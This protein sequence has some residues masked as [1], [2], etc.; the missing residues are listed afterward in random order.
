[1]GCALRVVAVLI[2]ALAFAPG[3]AAAAAKVKPKPAPVRGVLLAPGQFKVVGIVK[4]GRIGGTWHAGTL[5]KSGRFV[6]FTSQARSARTSARKLKGTARRK[7][8][9]TAKRYEGNV[10]SH[11]YYCKLKVPASTGGPNGLPYGQPPQYPQG[12]GAAL[13]FDI[14]DAVGLAT[15][16][17]TPN[18]SGAPASNIAAIDGAGRLQDAVVSGTAPVSQFLIAPN[19]KLYVLFSYPTALDGTYQS[20]CL[21]AEVE[22]STGVPRCIDATLSSVIWNSSYGNANPAIQFDDAGAIYYLGTAQ[23]GRLVLRRSSNAIVTDLIT[24]NAYA[25]DFVVLG[26]GTVVLTG[27]TTAT[28]APWTRRLSPRGELRTLRA[29]TSSFLRRFPDGNVYFGH[30]ESGG[31]GVKRYLAGPDAVDARNWIGYGRGSFDEPEENPPH[32]D[33]DDLCGSSSSG[34]QGFCSGSGATL[35]K[36]FT[37]TD[38]KV[39]AIAGYGSAGELMQYFPKVTRPVTAVKKVAVAQGVITNVALSGLDAQDRNVTTLYDTTD[40][41]ESVLI[42]PEQEIEVYH[43][44]YV[45]AGNR[46]LFDGLRF[47]DNS[48]VLGQVDLTT[49]KVTTTAVISSRLLGFQ[50]FR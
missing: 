7:K 2:A 36:T 49:G 4:C 22:P 3:A 9:A 11:G 12:P 38:R 25:A 39:Y 30:Q 24:D 50:T 46:I 15:Q 42:G 27:Q 23:D 41:S 17:P 5:A 1:M 44:N 48:Y 14:D 29:S 45:A 8:L 13:R 31:Y 28:S 32:H 26:D 34:N 19:D 10:V 21:L 33:L 35:Q 43:L 40:G 47:A 16:S 6:T 20:A 37:T 18:P